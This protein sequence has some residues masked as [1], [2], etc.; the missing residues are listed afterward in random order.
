M[1]K[2]RTIT[3]GDTLIEPYFGDDKTFDAI[4]SNP[5]NSVKWIGN[6]DQHLLM[7]ID[8]NLLES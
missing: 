8:M 5:S 2:E 7:I 6:E 3:L 1:F 4:V